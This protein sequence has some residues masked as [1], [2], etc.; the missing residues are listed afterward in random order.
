MNCRMNENKEQNMS[1]HTSLFESAIVM[2]VRAHTG[3]VR[4]GSDTP[5]IVHPM[6]A[7]AIAATMTNN[8][9]ILAATYGDVLWQRFN[10]KDK[11][12]HAWY[13]REM[14]KA[15]ACLSSHHAYTEYLILL[16]KV[17]GT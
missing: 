1:N 3:M 16:D 17:F 10:Q 14:G 15:L 9:E 5:Y 7:S 11:A 12:M 4:K 2:A 8:D 13:Y 6:E